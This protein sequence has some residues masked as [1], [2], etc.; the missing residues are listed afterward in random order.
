MSHEDIDIVRAWKD[1]EYRNSLSEEQRAQ[2]PENP[3]GTGE[4]SDE[5]METVAGGHANTE[6]KVL[7]VCIKTVGAGDPCTNVTGELLVDLC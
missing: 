3:A 6:K 1:E 7:G 2:L 4:L 5:T